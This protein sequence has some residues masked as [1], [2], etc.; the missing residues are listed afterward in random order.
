[1]RDKE[2]RCVMKKDSG[3]PG[4][5]RHISGAPG[6]L[7]VRGELPDDRIPSVAVIGAR[8]CSG[9]GREMAQWFAGELAAAGVQIISGMALGVDG[10]AQRAALS[11]GGKSFG[12]LGCGTDI[13]YPRANGDLYEMLLEKGGIL[14]EHPQ[15]TPPLARHFPSRNRIIS[16][17]S[18]VVLVVEAKEK[19]GTLITVD[20]AL[21]QGKDVYV[22]PGRLTD[23]LSCGCNRLLRQGAGIALA[24]SDILEG[25]YGKCGLS[26]VCRDTAPISKGEEENRKMRKPERLVW[27][28][29]GDRPVTLQELYQEIRESGDGEGMELPEVMHVLMNFVMQGIVLQE[30]GNQYQKR[31]GTK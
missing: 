30:R 26:A 13:C 16:A 11:A 22:L 31:M 19:S 12:V 6:R 15:G 27:D 25:F 4:A 24:P 10:I 2:E 23:D 9:Y 7:Y 18:D 29:M 14:S 5:L 20:F 1:M 3:Y 8:R 17:L 28:H 21:E